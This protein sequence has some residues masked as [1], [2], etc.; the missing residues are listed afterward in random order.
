VDVVAVRVNQCDG[1]A[2]QNDDV[3]RRGLAAASP[4]PSRLTFHEVQNS[5]Y[6]LVNG[7]TGMLSAGS[8]MWGSTDPLSRVDAVSS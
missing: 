3:A 8:T 6:T 5:P 2:I 4:T 7:F 1:G